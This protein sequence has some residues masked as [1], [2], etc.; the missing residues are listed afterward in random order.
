MEQQLQGKHLSM[1]EKIKGAFIKGLFVIGSA[2]LIF[3][4]VRNSL[5]WYMVQFWGGA[6]DVWQQMWDNF[7]QIV[8]K[9]R[10]LSSAMHCRKLLFYNI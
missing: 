2:M 1:S 4:S 8:G 9:L 5:T 3:E 6:G 7:L 10:A